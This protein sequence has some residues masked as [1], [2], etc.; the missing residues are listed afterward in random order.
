MHSNA[1]NVPLAQLHR[2]V[3]VVCVLHVIWENMGAVEV[4]V[5]IAH[6]VVIKIAKESFSVKIVMLIHI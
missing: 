2:K 1:I 5:P 6:L 3:E 4:H